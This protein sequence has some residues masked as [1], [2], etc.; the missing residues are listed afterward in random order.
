[1][2][3]LNENEYI[4]YVSSGL[5]KSDGSW[6]HPRRVTDSFEIIFMYDGT[7]YIGE[8]GEEYV[9][10]KNDVLFLERG[11]EH[12]GFRTSEEFVSFAWLHFVTNS[13]KYKAI[14]KCFTASNPNALKNLFSQC[15]HAVNTP[16]YDRVCADLYTALFAE[17]IL[18]SSRPGTASAN[19][20]AASIKEYVNANADKNLSVSGVADRFGYHENHT[21]RVF[22]SA[23]GTG[24]K[25]YILKRKIE[26]AEALLGTT[27]YTVG[28]IA[29]MLSFKSENHFIKFFKYH[30][31]LTPTEYRNTYINTHVNKS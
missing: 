10:R 20:L 21:S 15:M 11:K 23:Y 28:R 3:Y 24:L 8:E 19:M 4:E 1:M 29:Y 13:E 17:E 27:L 25:E 22:K 7:A 6:R 30:T 31:G 14:K 18:R 12:Y 2:I 16:N 5:F 9:L 26:Y